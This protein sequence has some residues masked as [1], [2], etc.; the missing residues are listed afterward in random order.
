MYGLVQ[1][2]RAYYDY[3]IEL[4][5]LKAECTLKSGKQEIVKEISSRGMSR[6]MA[7]CRER[8]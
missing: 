2:V 6:L 4:A 3:R 5:P 8:L 1:L 7:S